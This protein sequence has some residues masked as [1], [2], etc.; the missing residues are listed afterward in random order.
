[1]GLQ[2]LIQKK[3]ADVTP[4]RWRP[5][6]VAVSSG[7]TA[8]LAPFDLLRW[9][10][11]YYGFGSFFHFV[12][13][14][15]NDETVSEAN[16]VLEQLIKQGTASHAGVYL[17]TVISPNFR[18][19]ISQIVQMPGIF[20]I[21]N[22]SIL[23][24]LAHD[25]QVSM[26]DIAD[27]CHLAAMLSF[28]ICILR[29]SD[30]HFGYKKEIHIW[31]T[32]DDYRDANLM[33]LLAYILMG[34]SEWKGCS[35]EVFAVFQKTGMEEQMKQLNQLIDS[36]RI[37]ISYRHTKRI[38]FESDSQSFEALVSEHSEGADLV[39]VGFSLR[40][41]KEEKGR[42][43]SNFSG[44]SDILFVRAGQEIIISEPPGQE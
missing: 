43:F 26:K 12:K 25:K 9:I 14:S 7:S 18:T 31:I 30:R 32:P 6:F 38:P 42:L 39:V 11:R 1:M 41:L 44:I 35:I 21:E 33:I 34:H 28:N 16:Q 4:D 24:D 22:N 8:H 29:S 27:G 3:R 19:A 5:S 20:G 23:F 2:I 17:D 37:P 10:S 36:G 40:K 13:G 15:L